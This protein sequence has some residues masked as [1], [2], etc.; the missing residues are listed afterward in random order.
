MFPCKRIIVIISRMV[1]N[2]SKFKYGIMKSAQRILA[3][4]LE[5]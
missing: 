5:F 1:D 4:I 3:E 2:Y